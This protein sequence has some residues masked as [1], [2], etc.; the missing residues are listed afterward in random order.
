MEIK[1]PVLNEADKNRAND[2]YKYLIAVNRACTKEEL[3]AAI[4]WQYNKSNERRI[5]ELVSSLAKVE[6]IIST[7]DTTGY[8]LARTS[9]DRE[10]VVHQLNELKKRS[11]EIEARYAPLVNFLANQ[12]VYQ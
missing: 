8:R 3:C 12:K 7:S 4:G 11:A 10:D 2:I 1:K 5:R 6:P 9:L